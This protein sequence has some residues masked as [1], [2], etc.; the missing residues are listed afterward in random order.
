MSDYPMSWEEAV[1]WLRGQPDMQQ[2]VRDCYYDDPLLEAAE[3]FWS[4]IEWRAI[5]EELAG[6]LGRALDL[7][8]GR[9]IAAYALARDGWEVTALEPD[10]SHLVGAGAIGSLIAE[11]G[12]SVDIITDWGEKLP[13]DNASFD[14]VHCRQALHHAADL[15]QMLS[16]VGRVL[17]SGGCFIATREHVIS[18]REDLG[19]F[20]KS[21][22]LHHLYGGENAYTLAE[23]RDAIT[24]A[25]IVLDKCLN[26]FASEINT[27]PRTRKEIKRIVASRFRFPFP[28][29]IPDRLVVWYGQRNNTPG[30]PYTFVGHRSPRPGRQ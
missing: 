1:A 13:F 2:L 5:R 9:G 3:R 4:S 11:A 29:L 15:R 16:E 14:V 18:K 24:A 12:L 26:P 8:S 10:P 28:S 20:L 7:G 17:R 19:A 25:G 30:R 23:Y 21:H 6:K 27:F 22:P